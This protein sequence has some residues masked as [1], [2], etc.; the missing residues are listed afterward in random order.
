MGWPAGAGRR[1]RSGEGAVWR[2]GRAGAGLGRRA[3]MMRLEP[4]AARAEGRP[5]ARECRSHRQAE[6]A[7]Y[8]ASPPGCAGVEAHCR[9]AVGPGLGDG[10]WHMRGLMSGPVTRPYAPV[11]RQAAR[12]S[13][14]LWFDQA[15]ALP[16]G[17]PAGRVAE[18][19]RARCGHRGRPPD[20]SGQRRGIRRRH[21]RSAD[22]DAPERACGHACR[23]GAMAGDDAAIV[24]FRRSYEP[25]STPL[26]GREGCPAS[27]CAHARHRRW[28]APA[29]RMCCLGWRACARLRGQGLPALWGRHLI[30]PAGGMPGRAAPRRPL[31]RRDHPVLRQS[32]Q[33]HKH[34]PAAAATTD[35]CGGSAQ[36]MV[37][38]GGGD[39]GGAGRPGRAAARLAGAP[40]AG[41]SR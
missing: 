11:G 7:P 33:P 40:R 20:R 19:L 30:A 36:R 32:P 17:G 27:R 13:R 6:H 15:A 34:P 5:F 21:R 16:R 2:H 22:C 1:G 38:G 3:P 4:D 23:G 31:F 12:G 25:A 41:G 39:R 26:P 29:P 18:I 35:G 14:S 24:G 10:W 28:Q 37:P 8:P 9:R